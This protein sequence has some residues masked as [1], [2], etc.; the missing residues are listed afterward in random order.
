[1]LCQLCTFRAVD[2]LEPHDVVNSEFQVSL[3]A[4]ELDDCVCELIKFCLWDG[5]QDATSSVPLCGQ[6]GFARKSSEGSITG[7][8]VSTVGK[9][10]YAL[11]SLCFLPSPITRPFIPLCRSNGILEH[12]VAIVKSSARPTETFYNADVVKFAFEVLH[13]TCEIERSPGKAWRD[14]KQVCGV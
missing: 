2:R 5:K 3:L 8:S 1:M 4:R 9:L 7:L 10:K 6:A 13:R 14:V 12:F 11:Y